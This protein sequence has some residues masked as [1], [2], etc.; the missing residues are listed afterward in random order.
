MKIL[1][2]FL[3]GG[4]IILTSSF[5]LPLQE[6]TAYSPILMSRTELEKSIEFQ[7]A[8]TISD[9]GKIYKKGQWVYITEKYKGIHVIDN[10]NPNS[11]LNKGFIRVPGCVD[12]SVKANS[13]YADNSMDLVAI[14]ISNFST[15]QVTERIRNV[16]PEP[17]P[18]DLRYIPYKYQQSNR[19]E[20]TMIV[21][22][23]KNI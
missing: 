11:P 22:W 15:I 16:F 8:K 18:P 6:E 9:I 23:K 4:I 14:D 10:S 2:L 12:I 3:I 7:P 19:P 21:E 1:N 17:L 5:D 20:N 13:L